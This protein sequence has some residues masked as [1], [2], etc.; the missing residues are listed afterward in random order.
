MEK[1]FV[2]NHCKE[3][4]LLR[5]FKSGK[6]R[7]SSLCSYCR[8]KGIKENSVN[9]DLQMYV[10][11]T[12]KQ[13]FS[14]KPES[15]T[16]YLEHLNNF[17]RKHNGNKYL[18]YIIYLDRYCE[19]QQNPV[20]RQNALLAKQT[21]SYYFVNGA[22]TDNES[23]V[24]EIIKNKELVFD[25]NL[26]AEFIFNTKELVNK[27]NKP[28]TFVAEFNGY[29]QSLGRAKSKSEV[30]SDRNLYIREKNE[31]KKENE[32][33]TCFYCNGM[34]ET[35]DHYVPLVLGGSPIATENVVPCC[36]AC[37]NLKGS[38][39]PDIFEEMLGGLLKNSTEERTSLSKKNNKIQRELADIQNQIEYLTYLL[40]KQTEQFEKN[41]Q[42]HKQIVTAQ[43][44]V[45]QSY[46]KLEDIEYL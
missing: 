34:Y 23:E 11:K 20:K 37:N 18:F 44:T 25:K 2:C 21:L 10:T 41:E 9:F 3:G 29:I 13:T 30:I 43:R 33:K 8:T 15:S 42:K 22:C 39:S 46:C 7:Y 35:L 27:T 45:I 4:R 36:T 17:Y 16:N 6:D 28:R 5:S 31:L 26:K 14:M 32:G 40:E 1:Y 38:L 24:F 12:L 19:N